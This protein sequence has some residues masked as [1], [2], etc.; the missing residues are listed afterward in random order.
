MAYTMHRETQMHLWA[1]LSSKW[2]SKDSRCY[3]QEARIR[4]RR[5]NHAVTPVAM[6]E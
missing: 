1:D 5:G 6:L 4:A 3:M 2:E